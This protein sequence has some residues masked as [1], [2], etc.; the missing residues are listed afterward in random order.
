MW[1][2]REGRGSG[3]FYP[4]AGYFLS[5]VSNDTKARFE[6]GAGF[7]PT[8]LIA[9]IKS[10]LSEKSWTAASTVTRGVSRSKRQA[11]ATL[12]DKKVL[13]LR[14]WLVRC[15][16]LLIGCLW[17]VLLCTLLLL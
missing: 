12:W 5:G 10:C 9:S 2:D 8:T 6:E 11:A 3:I 17:N 14:D 4:Q 15:V 13:P 1:Y 16:F 7:F